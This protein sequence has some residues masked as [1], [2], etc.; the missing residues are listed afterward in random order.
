MVWK[1]P[2]NKYRGTRRPYFSAFFIE[3]FFSLKASSLNQKRAVHFLRKLNKRLLHIVRSH[4]ELQEISSSDSITTST[5]I[6]EFCFDSRHTNER[7]LLM[8]PGVL[9]AVEEKREDD[10]ARTVGKKPQNFIKKGKN[11]ITNR[12]WLK[13]TPYKITKV[14]AAWKMS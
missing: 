2:D 8:L 9:A 4:L 11:C 10:M 3:Q 5:V 1:Y 6:L 14:T 13:F 12:D 7:Y